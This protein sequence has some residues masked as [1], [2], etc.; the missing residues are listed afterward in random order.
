MHISEVHNSSSFDKRVG[1]DIN[2]QIKI[3][4]LPT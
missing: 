2:T 3:A 1:S 4:F